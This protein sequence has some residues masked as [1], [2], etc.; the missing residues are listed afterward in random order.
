ML[1]TRSWQQGP[2]RSGGIGRRASLRGWCPK[3]CGGSSPPSD[4]TQWEESHRAG[5]SGSTVELTAPA[6]PF[7]TV[8][9]APTSRAGRA[10][11]ASRRRCC[12]DETSRP[13]R[14]RA[15][16]GESAALATRQES[17]V[18]NWSQGAGE[19]APTHLRFLPCRRGALRQAHRLPQRNGGPAR[20]PPTGPIAASLPSVTVNSP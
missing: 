18:H 16:T 20:P 5:F 8:P 14:Q 17:G 4:T 9:G 6:S 2:R 7:P 13:R 11:L 3:G 12:S 15:S 10:C 19:T 1:S